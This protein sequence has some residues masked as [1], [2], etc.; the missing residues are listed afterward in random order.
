MQHCQ[1]SIPSVGTRKRPGIHPVALTY[2][3]LDLGLNVLY[4]NVAI[5]LGKTCYHSMHISSI[6]LNVKL[7]LIF[8]IYYVKDMY[9]NLFLNASIF[10]PGS[11]A[12]IKI[13]Y[14]HTLIALR[15]SCYVLF[16]HFAKIVLNRSKTVNFNIHSAQT[17][18]NEDVM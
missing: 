1:E 5:Y 11:E 13:K 7:L 16:P 6:G 12:L 9:A 17:E 2:L 18:N 8:I 15:G 10:C 4:S 3:C 14:T